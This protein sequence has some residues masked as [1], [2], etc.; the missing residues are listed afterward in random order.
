MIAVIKRQQAGSK[1]S[2]INTCAA[3]LSICSLMD[4]MEQGNVNGKWESEI[5][6]CN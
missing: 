3:L 6:L 1:V 4:G 2:K 5:K